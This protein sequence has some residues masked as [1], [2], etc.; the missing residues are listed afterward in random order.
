MPT[1]YY[2]L[3]ISVS[4]KVYKKNIHASKKYDLNWNTVI[5]IRSS[6]SFHLLSDNKRIYSKVIFKSCYEELLPKLLIKDLEATSGG[7]L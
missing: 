7:A 5:E 6:V 3:F 1:Q 2:I 4:C